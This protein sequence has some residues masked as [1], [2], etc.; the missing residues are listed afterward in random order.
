MKVETTALSIKHIAQMYCV[1]GK[2][3]A[4]LYRNRISGYADWFDRE[5]CCGFY[6]NAANIG[7]YMSLDETCLSNGEV[8]T[9]LTNKDGHGGKGTLAAAIPGT[10]SD[11]IISI[12]IAAMS[13]SVRRKV[14]EVT[15]DL[16]PSMMLIAGEVFYNAHVVNDRFHVQQ[17]YNEAVDEIRI[18]IRRQLIAEENIRDKSTTPV[19]YSNGETMRQILAR[20]KHTLMMSQNKWTDIQRHRV[21]ILFKYH[22]ILKR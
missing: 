16:S 17:V 13:K 9:F 10:K 5:L 22:P 14:K 7:P 6:F 18:D 4:D 2:Y 3:F 15:C 8:W 20:S 21:N 11:E 12:L 1:N 19:T